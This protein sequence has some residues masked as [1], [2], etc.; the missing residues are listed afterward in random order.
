[1]RWNL[2]CQH[3]RGKSSWNA[4]L[5]SLENDAVDDREFISRCPVDL[6]AGVTL[7][8]LLRPAELDVVA[9]ASHLLVVTGSVLQLLCL[10]IADQLDFHGCV[11]HSLKVFN[12]VIMWF[13]WQEFPRQSIG[14]RDAFARNVNDGEVIF[15]AV[16]VISTA[17]QVGL[18]PFFLW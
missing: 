10:H 18:L 12:A 4:T 17:V 7:L 16:V 14:Y 1:M 3:F 6:H 15:L 5:F 11:N 2:H 9:N 13:C 8:A